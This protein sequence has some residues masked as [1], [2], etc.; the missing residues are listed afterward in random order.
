MSRYTV[1][2][3]RGCVVIH[4][5]IPVDDLVAL[6][7]VWDDPERPWIAHAALGQALGA[8]LVVGPP[9]ACQAWYD[10]LTQA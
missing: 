9:E 8:A 10:E 6:V 1:E 4:D 3:I 2:R 5:P 7:K